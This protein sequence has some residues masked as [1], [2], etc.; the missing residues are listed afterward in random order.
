[1]KG[2]YF[3]RF[4]CFFVK[5]IEK[6]TAEKYISIELGGEKMKLKNEI[7]KKT[8]SFVKK[9]VEH[10]CKVDANS[11]TCLSVYQPKAPAALKN[12]SKIN[13]E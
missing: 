10:S 2:I 5:N 6:Q 8:A 11:T 4:Y 3:I 13:K 1:M 9:A 12:F 7:Q